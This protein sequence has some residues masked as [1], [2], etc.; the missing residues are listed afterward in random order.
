MR[1]LI[2]GCLGT[3]L[4]LVLMLVVLVGVGWWMLSGEPDNW[5]EHE[6]FLQRTTQAERDAMAH[7]LQNRVMTAA[8]TGPANP[9]A[10]NAAAATAGAAGG[11]QTVELELD[12]INAWLDRQLRQWAA[13]QGQPL[14]A[15]LQGIAV[16]AQGEDVVITMRVNSGERSQLVTVAGGLEV[17]EDGRA[18]LRLGKLRVGR[19]PVPMS[20]V[21]QTLETA[22]AQA[23]G[24]EE[25]VAW[26]LGVI[27]GEP[28][29]PV[30][31]V[32]GNP[33]VRVVAV[34]AGEEAVTVTLREAETSR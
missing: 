1:K 24:E 33:P 27:R 21:T 3:G 13:N 28:F 22:L 7:R 31:Q 11:D 5:E 2:V 26:V 6:A 19:L 17:A 12:S 16:G 20:W 10:A 30:L 9:P 32:G 15:E 18:S 29:D 23:G 4:M 34:E 25:A 8:T 14:P